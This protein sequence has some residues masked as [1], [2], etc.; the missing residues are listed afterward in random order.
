MTDSKSGDGM[1]GKMVG[2]FASNLRF[3]QLFTVMLVVFLVDLVVPDIIPFADEILFGLL[4]V[5]LGSLKRD[6]DGPDDREPREPR[7]PREKNVTPGG[8]RHS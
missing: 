1:I 5:L 7:E 4:T 2:D 6:G 8:G 3:P